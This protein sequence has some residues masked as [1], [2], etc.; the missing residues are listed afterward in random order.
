MQVLC[1][2]IIGTAMTI[3][4]ALSVSE[5]LSI[6]AWMAKLAPDLISR[7]FT[8]P[9]STVSPIGWLNL[10]KYYSYWLNVASAAKEIGLGRLEDEWRRDCLHIPPVNT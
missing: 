7:G 10:A 5:A 6:P 4:F 9:G 2:V 1:D 3:T 8:G